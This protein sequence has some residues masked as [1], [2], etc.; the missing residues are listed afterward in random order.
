MFADPMYG[1]NR[2]AAG[3]RLIGY[4]GPRFGYTHAEMQP[5]ADLAAQ[6]VTTLADLRDFYDR[7]DD[8]DPKW[9]ER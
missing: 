9:S 4:P 8:R 7:G 5:G 1:G 2:N 3:W 6:P